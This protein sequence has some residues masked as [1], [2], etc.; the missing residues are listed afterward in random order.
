MVNAPTISPDLMAPILHLL[1]Y[2][3][4]PLLVGAALVGTLARVLLDQ[5]ENRIL[6]WARGV[7]DSRTAHESDALPGSTPTDVATESPQCPS[8]NRIMVPRVARK[9]PTAA[10]S[11]WGC[12]AYPQ[13]RA[14]RDMT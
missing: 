11:F 12:S 13:C 10:G 8:C 9:G 3:A 14:T 1:W 7:R 5:A 2:R 6:R 4:V